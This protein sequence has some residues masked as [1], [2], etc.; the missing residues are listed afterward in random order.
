[1]P[2]YSTKEL[3]ERKE[4][5]DAIV[6]NLEIINEDGNSPDYLGELEKLCRSIAANLKEIAGDETDL[7][8][9]RN[10][11]DEIVRNL[12]TIAGQKSSKHKEHS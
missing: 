5:T 8:E 9:M 1:M 6:R 7:D 2:E 4:L 3:R 11:T 12:T 10:S